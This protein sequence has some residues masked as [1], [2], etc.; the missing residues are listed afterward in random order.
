[1][2]F[3]LKFF[4]VIAVLVVLA[5]AGTADP[6]ASALL[7]SGHMDEAVS[8]LSTR[9]D[10][11]SLN[12]LSR[13]YYAMERWDESV[14]FGERAVSLDP[15]NASY[16]LWLAREYG[17]KA[18]EANP[19]SAASLARKAK[20]EFERAVQLDPRNVPARVDLAEYYTEAPSVMGGGLDKARQQA[21]QVAKYDVGNAHLILARAAEKE[22]QYGEAEA[23][24]R[25][26]IQSA[27]NPADMW[28]QLAAFYRQHGRFDDMQK[29]VH[30]AMAQPNKPAESYFDAATEL[31]LGSR[32]FSGAMQYLQ[33]YLSSGALVESAP[34]F[35]AHYLI[36]QLNEK[37]G[38]NGAAASEYSAS[39][40]LASG[41]G[42]AR[43]ALSRVQ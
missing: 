10:A 4:V 31:Y 14:K 23:Q 39:L 17:R 41:F 36:G 30:S 27:K 42:P 8:I 7:S 13:A 19:L 35:R 29:A 5:T 11:E 33:R 40:A 37:M 20:S 28:L 21:E 3:V 25:D 18:S 16:H 15:N 12:Q 43:K 24:Y 6:A 1:M 34:A 32:D 22:K 38:N 26:A 9:S 2:K